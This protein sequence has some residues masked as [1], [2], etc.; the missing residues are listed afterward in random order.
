MKSVYCVAVTTVLLMKPMIGPLD[1]YQ[2]IV[3]AIHPALRY[4]IHTVGYKKHFIKQACDRGT[5]NT[6]IAGTLL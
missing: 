5:F 2:E 6:V 3:R 1:G 4:A